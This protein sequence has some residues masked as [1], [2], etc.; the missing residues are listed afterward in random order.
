MGVGVLVPPGA[1]RLARSRWP[2]ATVRHHVEQVAD[3]PQTREAGET[4]AALD[5]VTDLVRNWR[6]RRHMH[7]CAIAATHAARRLSRRHAASRFLRV[8]RSASTSCC[9]PARPPARSTRRRR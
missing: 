4:A 1:K 8:P 9:L 7:A 3:K 2:F 6:C 5:K